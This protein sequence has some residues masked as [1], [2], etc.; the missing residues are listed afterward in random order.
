MP[1]RKAGQ[2]SDV[3]DPKL[4]AKIRSVGLDGLHRQ[5]QVVGNRLRRQ[6]LRH[7]F[8]DATL[9]G[10]EHAQ[11]LV[12]TP[13]ARIRRDLGVIIPSGDDRVKRVAEDLKRILLVHEAVR[14]RIHRLGDEMFTRR[15]AIHEH[16]S[17]TRFAPQLTDDL[18]A[19][20]LR[21]EEIQH[22]NA[23]L[24][25]AT[26]LDRIGAVI[27]FPDDHKGTFARED[28]RKHLP[29]GGVIIDQEDADL[30]RTCVWR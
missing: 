20:D 15:A 29:D 11:A 28:E 27:H 30:F 1:D 26:F 8:Q 24:K 19:T 6:P 23:G 25:F 21:E 13:F 18:H 16:P 12:S 22:D 14:L 7:Q 9:P 17:F 2:R 3:V 10:C 4:L 5:V